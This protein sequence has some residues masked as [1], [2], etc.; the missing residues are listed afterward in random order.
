MRCSPRALIFAREV[1]SAATC[2]LSVPPCTLKESASPPAS[3]PVGFALHF[4]RRRTLIRRNCIFSTVVACLL[5]LAVV[6][7]SAP[8]LAQQ[9]DESLFKGMKWRLIGP[10]RG[11]RALPPAAL[12]GNPKVYPSG[13]VAE[14]GDM[15]FAGD[16]DG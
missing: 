8:L 2:R 7:I 6:G 1:V 15:G 4:F 11:G 10:S 13:G 9:Y 12:P 3:A 16:A 14:V 5:L